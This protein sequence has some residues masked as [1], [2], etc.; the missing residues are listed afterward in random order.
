M[1]EENRIHRVPSTGF[2]E[3]SSIDVECLSQFEQS[4]KKTGIKMGN[5]LQ[6]NRNFGGMTFD[7]I[8]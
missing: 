1:N 3:S 7:Q 8:K 4:P 5:Y 2:E 6:N